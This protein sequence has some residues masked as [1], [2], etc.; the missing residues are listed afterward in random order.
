M[1]FFLLVLSPA[2]ESL[3]CSG[4]GWSSDR[5]NSRKN[6]RKVPLAPL[7]GQRYHL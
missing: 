7:A 3:F 1:V 2:T 4:G 6:S 5:Q